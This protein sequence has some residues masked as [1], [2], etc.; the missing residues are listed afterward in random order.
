MLPVAMI[1]RVMDF[2]GTHA[3]SRRGRPGLGQQDNTPARNAEP[4]RCVDPGS[5]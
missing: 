1:E 2:I 4:A 3:G 5:D